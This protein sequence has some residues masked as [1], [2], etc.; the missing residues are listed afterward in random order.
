MSH[1]RLQFKVLGLLFMNTRAQIRAELSYDF[2][3]IKRR[4][5]LQAFHVP[6]VNLDYRSP[7]W[8]ATLVFHTQLRQAVRVIFKHGFLALD[9]EALMDVIVDQHEVE[10]AVFIK[11]AR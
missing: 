5:M 7:F 1:L 10:P 3:E 11:I 8:A 2:V 6:S 9:L 4:N